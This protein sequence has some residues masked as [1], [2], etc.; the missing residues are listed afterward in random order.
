MDNQSFNIDELFALAR[1][2]A[3]N[4]SYDETSKKFLSSLVLAAGGVL[5]TKGIISLFTKKW[6]IMTT[7][8]TVVSTTAVV[9]ATSMSYD[10][11]ELSE[12]PI[13]KPSNQIIMGS[14]AITENEELPVMPEK[15]SQSEVI[16]AF[17][18]DE[19]IV[20]ID[21]A[22]DGADI[23]LVLFEGDTCKNKCKHKCK[24]N[25][26]VKVSTGFTE[27]YVITQNT[28][29][30]ELNEIK[31]RALDAGID[32][33]Y[34]A[35]FKDGKL[36]KINIQMELER[37]D[38]N[39]YSHITSITNEKMEEGNEVIFG[40]SEDEEGKATVV[41]MG[42][43]AQVDINIDLDLEESLMDLEE[44]LAELEDL[45]IE[46]SQDTAYWFAFAEGM[47][48]IA[49]NL[50]EG[51]GELDFDFEF[52][53][54]DLENFEGIDEEKMEMLEE[55]MEQL[56]EELEKMMEELEIELEKL[57][58][59]NGSKDSYHNPKFKKKYRRRVKFNR[60]G[61][62]VRFKRR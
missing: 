17:A 13:D 33:D 43:G 11:K 46:F 5:A 58:K 54:D 28:S 26:W 29:E 53:F 32:F 42:D 60:Y 31:Q 16:N 23:D 61:K 40:W 8:F 27:K 2:E 55:R 41:G 6:I 15:V 37:D 34:K 45:N 21:E 39:G 14:P 30:Q 19:G 24:D 1:E 59:D 36:S 49:E 47:E 10:N 52:N 62:R 12:A 20:F 25:S 38:E 22:P 51:L 35:H 50:G 9:V 44:S 48:T 56:G 18:E 3:P 4:T 57:N 7:L